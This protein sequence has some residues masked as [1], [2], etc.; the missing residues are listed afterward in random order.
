[1]WIQSN[2]SNQSSQNK[3]TTKPQ[4]QQ[5]HNKAD[6]ELSASASAM[7]DFPRAKQYEELSATAARAKDS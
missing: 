6:R 5:S 4:L 3:A 2:Q 1:M 7:C